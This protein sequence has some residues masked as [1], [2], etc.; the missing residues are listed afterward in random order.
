MCV[1]ISPSATSDSSRPHDAVEPA[2]LPWHGALQARMLE[3]VTIPKLKYIFININ[4]NH[5]SQHIFANEK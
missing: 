2:R 5:Y 3:W 4:R 1:F